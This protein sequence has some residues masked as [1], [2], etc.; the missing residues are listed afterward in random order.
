MSRYG[1]PNENLFKI[2]FG[3]P[4]QNCGKRWLIALK[5]LI[6]KKW[7]KGPFYSSSSP[8]FHGWPQKLVMV[9][10]KI[11]VLHSLLHFAF[12]ITHFQK[13]FSWHSQLLFYVHEKGNHP[14][15]IDKHEHAEER[16]ERVSWYSTHS[17]LP[18]LR[19]TARFYDYHFKNKKEL[20]ISETKQSLKLVHSTTS[21]F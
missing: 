7:L 6:T 18:E 13:T 12:Q 20:L 2:W 8:P 19:K 17:P 21:K 15:R 4:N 11:I 5:Q 14:S 10:L 3:D 16:R 1:S 9:F